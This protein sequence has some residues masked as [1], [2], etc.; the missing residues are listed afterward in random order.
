VRT[1]AKRDSRSRNPSA[2]RNSDAGQCRK[3]SRPAVSL[4]RLAAGELES[5]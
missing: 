3:G 5:R 4:P 2:E 1:D